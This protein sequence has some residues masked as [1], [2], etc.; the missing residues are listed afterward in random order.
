MLLVP[1]MFGNGMH[2]HT[3]GA[4]ASADWNVVNRWKLT[5]S[6]SWLNMRLRLDPTSLDTSHATAAAGDSP[7]S[8]F[9]VRSYVTLPGRFDFDSS[10]YYVDRLPSINTP[11]YTR[12]DARLA[13]H[14]T[15]S[16]ELSVV[17]QNL[18]DE[19]HFEF[20]NA[21]DQL[22]LSSQVKRSVYGKVT[23]RFK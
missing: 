14:P 21:A 23:W 10:L 16:I 1:Q 4:E 18:L 15:E 11:A 9:Q 20:T 8:Q 2:G 19:R 12:V 5:G 22:Y 7:Q 13:W 17:G 3:Y 6:Y